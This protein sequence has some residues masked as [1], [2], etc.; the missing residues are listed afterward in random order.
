MSEE[1]RNL[2]NEGQKEQF[3][4]LEQEARHIFDKDNA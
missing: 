1:D 4:N 2:M 3:K